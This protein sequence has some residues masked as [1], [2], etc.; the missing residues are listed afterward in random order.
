MDNVEEAYEL[1]LGPEAADDTDPAAECKRGVGELRDAD[2][3]RL[4]K[5]LALPTVCNEGLSSRGGEEAL[6]FWPVVALG[7]Y[8]SCRP[9][10]SSM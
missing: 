1:A 9:E 7:E 5:S 6:R 2:S 8:G 10:Y 3:L 4:N